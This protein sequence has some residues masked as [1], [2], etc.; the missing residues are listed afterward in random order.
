MLRAYIRLRMG[1]ELRRHEGSSDLVQSVCRA[2]LQRSERFVPDSRANFAHWAF[3]TALR[4]IRDR[5]RHWQA[6]KRAPAALDEGHLS[7]V[8]CT[9]L[10]ESYGRFAAPSQVAVAR[11]RIEQIERCFDRLSPLQR[12]VIILARIQGLSHEEIAARL[13]RRPA[14]VRMLLSRALA[15]L[16]TWLD[17]DGQ[18]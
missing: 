16:S 2:V 12:E 1:P 14:A 10:L 15:R 13:Q 5:A 3:E 17:I 7:D 11:E 4:L 8:D 18:E 9:Q 6:A